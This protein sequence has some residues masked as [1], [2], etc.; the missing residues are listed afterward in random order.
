MKKRTFLL[1]ILFIL[2]LLLILFVSNSCLS[3]EKYADVNNNLVNVLYSDK[4]GNMG[5]TS[6]LGLNSLTVNTNTEIKG[7]LK[8]GGNT[9]LNSG[10]KVSGNT[11]LNSGLTVSGN[12]SLNNGLTIS[13]NT[14]LNN[15]L[16]VNGN[17]TL[18]NDLTVNGKLTVQSMDILAELKYLREYMTKLASRVILTDNFYSIQNS[19]TTKFLVSHNDSPIMYGTDCYADGKWKFIQQPAGD[20]C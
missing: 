16:T 11:S 7:E 5:S 19:A 10:L 8:T 6:N 12:T 3:K 20:H 14:S 9:S 17:S 1:I 4:D 18:N 2:T 13:G 15:G